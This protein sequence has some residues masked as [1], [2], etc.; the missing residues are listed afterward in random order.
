[1]G[2]LITGAGRVSSSMRGLI[3]VARR[4]LAWEPYKYQRHQINATIKDSAIRPS[5]ST[6]LRCRREREAYTR[7]E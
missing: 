5:Q 6:K 3:L 2:I 1:M 4:A 7:S